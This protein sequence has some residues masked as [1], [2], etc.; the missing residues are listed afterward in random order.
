MGHDLLGL[1]ARADTIELAGERFAISPENLE[2][3]TVASPDQ[4]KTALPRTAHAVNDRKE[5][6][7]G[8]GGE[9]DPGADI[10]SDHRS[11]RP[12]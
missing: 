6:R 5:F 8:A 1:I 10:E 7:V 4:L 9:G 11:S 2:R 12:P 3:A